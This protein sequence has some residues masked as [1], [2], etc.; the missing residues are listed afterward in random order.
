MDTVGGWGIILPAVLGISP[1]CQ[2]IIRFPSSS[3]VDLPVKVDMF[4]VSRLLPKH[5]AGSVWA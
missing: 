3:L 2:V 1:L 4:S 5:P